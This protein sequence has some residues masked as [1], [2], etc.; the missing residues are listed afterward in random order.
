MATDTRT[1][2]AQ[3]LAARV[4]RGRAALRR[5]QLAEDIAA[6]LLTSSGL[7]LLRRNY[8]RRRGELDL[9]AREGD[10]LVIVEVRSRA[11][12]A[13]GS[14]AASIDFR[15]QRRIALAAALLLQSDREL[16]RLRV[17]FD[18]IIVSDPCS[19]HPHVEWI[20]SAFLTA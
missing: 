15:K 4:R 17:R 2:P 11:S 18:V 7:Q 9:V 1:T 6:R 20:R 16:A 12:S 13:Y 19:A 14:A 5:G 8:Q 10:E 3:E